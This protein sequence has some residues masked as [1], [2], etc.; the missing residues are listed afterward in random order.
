MKG[1]KRRRHNQ[2]PKV[3]KDGSF[4]DLEDSDVEEDDGAGDDVEVTPAKRPKRRTGARGVPGAINAHAD[5]LV[6]I[7]ET[8]DDDSPEPSRVGKPSNKKTVSNVA[9][10]FT[11]QK[12]AGTGTGN[13]TVAKVRE[14]PGLVVNVVM[15]TVAWARLCAFSLFSLCC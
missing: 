14:D 10:R 1:L 5:N 4:E 2:A 6:A 12:R 11:K 9:S 7:P 15:C 13:H 3:D 8:S